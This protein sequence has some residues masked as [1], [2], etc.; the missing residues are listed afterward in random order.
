MRKRPT[1]KDVARVAGVSHMTVSRVVNGDPGVHPRDG[2]RV[3]SRP[4]GELGY[5]RNDV[6]RHLRQKGP[7]DGA[8][9]G[10]SST[11][12]PTLFWS[13]LARAVEDEALRRGY[14][15]LVGSTN[16]DRRRE[17]A[18][19]VGVLLTSRRRP[20]SSCRSPAAS[21]SCRRRWRSGR[22]S[23]ASIAP[24][25][26]STVDVVVVD[27][28]AGSASRPCSHL[29]EHGHR[30]IAPRSPTRR[31]SGRPAERYAGYRRGAGALHGIEPRS[32]LCPA[33]AS[34]RRFT[35]R[36]LRSIGAAADAPDAADSV[37]SPATT[38]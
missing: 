33:R 14:L 6:A 7:G 18:V 32:R 25:T 30:R 4:S 15:V 2:A 20:R 29:I 38:C 9:S 19:R 26:G 3:S 24:R 1:M 22:T 17:R 16:N 13:A 34:A 28:R 10:S 31:T 37:R 11:T 8:R 21:A 27:D 12:S 23:C 36:R 35:G 5:Q